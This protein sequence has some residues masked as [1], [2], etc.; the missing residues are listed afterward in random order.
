M[1]RYGE[2]DYGQ[3]LS[4]EEYD[5]S[6]V[7]LHSEL[8]S[9]PSQE[10]QREV[11]RRELDLAID[12]RLGC[13]F[14]RSRRDALW[15]VQQKVERRRIRLMFKYLLRRFFAKSLIKDAQGL[16]GYLVEAYGT[17]LNRTELEC[18]FGEKEVRNP[19]L[20]IDAEQLKKK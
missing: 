11:R 17:V 5:R 4:D 8:P 13:D 1:A 20:P 7:A 2:L 12:Y 16:A 6:I 19:A 14:P 15:S 18:F 3:R 9:V 10:Q